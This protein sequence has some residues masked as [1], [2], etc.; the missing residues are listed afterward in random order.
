MDRPLEDR[1]AL[2]QNCAV[3]GGSLLLPAPFEEN[4]VA[5]YDE[6]VSRNLEGVV[7]K[8]RGSAYHAGARSFDW[9]KVKRVRDGEFVIGG[10]TIGGGRRKDYLSGILLG[11]VNEGGLHYC[12]R[13]VGGF[14][15][16]ERELLGG[17]ERLH[18]APC[19]YVT[20]PRTGEI[21]FFVTP[22]MVA[23]VRHAGWRAD[24]TLSFPVFLTLRPDVP[25]DE[26]RQEEVVDP[27]E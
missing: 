19:P 14:D 11:Y 2:L 13:V 25:A 26:C 16:E 4:G 17:L 5:L 18:A 7:A 12:G 10:Y 20:E 27:P 8:R 1:R 22:E 24:G 23:Q 21:T 6:V 3:Q 15:R 9:L